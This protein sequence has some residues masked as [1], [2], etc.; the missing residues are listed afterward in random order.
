MATIGFWFVNNLRYDIQLF[1]RSSPPYDGKNLGG[2]ITE[3]SDLW[4][5]A[6]ASLT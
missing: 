5:T 4:Q 6:K 1:L 3:V 2:P